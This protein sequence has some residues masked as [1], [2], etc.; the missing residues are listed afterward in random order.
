MASDALLG[1]REGVGGGVES[2]AV[3]VVGLR[4][5]LAIVLVVAVEKQAVLVVGAEKQAVL[6]VEVQK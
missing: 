6:V 4:I 1:L 5:F 2:R 3:L